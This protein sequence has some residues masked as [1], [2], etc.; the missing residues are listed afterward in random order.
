VSDSRSAVLGNIRR[1]LKRGEPTA[2]QRRAAEARIA[3]AK[4][5]LLPARG[6]LEPK[7]Q[8]ALFQEMAQEASATVTRGRMPPPCPPPSLITRAENCLARLGFDGNRH[9][10]LALVTLAA[11]DHP[12]D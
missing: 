7:A 3:A 1:A 12:G 8:A 10:Q 2:D 5:N 4:T 6:Q 9:H 11:G